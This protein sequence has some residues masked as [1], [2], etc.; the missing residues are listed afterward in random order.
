MNA[1]AKTLFQAD[2]STFWGR[3]ESIA[4][5]SWAGTREAQKG[6]VATEA[7]NDANHAALRSASISPT[8]SA[9]D[10]EEL[11]LRAGSA[12]LRRASSA[13]ASRT[14]GESRQQPLAAAQAAPALSEFLLS[15]LWPLLLLPS[16]LAGAEDLDWLAPLEAVHTREVYARISGPV[17][18]L[19]VQEDDRVTLGDTLLLL[20]GTEYRLRERTAYLAWTQ[21]QSRLERARPLYALGGLSTQALEELEYQAEAARLRW[22]QARTDLAHTLIRAPMD[23]IVNDCSLQVGALVNPGMR[24]CRLLDPTHL[25]AVLYLP[26]EQL[27]QVSPG[28][29]VRASSLAFPQRSI[30]GFIRHLSPLLDPASGR[31]QVELLFPRAGRSFRPGTL[32]QIH[33]TPAEPSPRRPRTSGKANNGDLEP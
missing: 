16:F 27:E 1:A 30:Q 25:K 5:R 23:G 18:S 9:I 6:L 29:S 2:T 28:Q 31:G 3:A 14:R 24:L 7:V 13:P 17:Q 12:S 32:V 19:A 22:E 4:A 20:E 33:L 26:P 15:W 21:E 8:R 10:L 11:D